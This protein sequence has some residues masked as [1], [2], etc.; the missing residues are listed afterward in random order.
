MPA[1]IVE[2]NK[3]RSMGAALISSR[4]HLARDYLQRYQVVVVKCLWLV[5][6]SGDDAKDV[7][8]KQEGAIIADSG[9]PG[10]SLAYCT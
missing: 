1:I 5:A 8:P 7:L 3:R 4:R 2:I 9:S 10:V 6:G